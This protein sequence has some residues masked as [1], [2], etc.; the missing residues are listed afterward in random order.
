MVRHGEGPLRS[1]NCAT[2]SQISRKPPA[3]HTIGVALAC[4]LVAVP[5]YV[6]SLGSVGG[7]ARA[8]VSPRDPGARALARASLHAGTFH[9][10]FD[11]AQMQ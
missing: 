7:L 10:A 9:E 2:R 3:A 8:V 5:P 6:V 4:S 11:A 1:K